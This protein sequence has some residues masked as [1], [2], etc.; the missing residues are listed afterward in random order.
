MFGLIKFFRE[1]AERQNLGRSQ[2]QRLGLGSQRKQL[3]ESSTGIR[4]GQYDDT[5]VQVP[6]FA[7]AIMFEKIIASCM[8]NGRGPPQKVSLDRL[9]LLEQRSSLPE[10]NFRH[11]H[12]LLY[13]PAKSIRPNIGLEMPF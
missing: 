7:P 1:F 9:R 11:R 3:Q 6:A 2:H 10:W 5:S 13:F 12:I 8:E 4:A